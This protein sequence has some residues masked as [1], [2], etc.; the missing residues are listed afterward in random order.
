MES[1]IESA[2]DAPPLSRFQT[3]SLTQLGIMRSSRT[4]TFEGVSGASSVSSNLN[5]KHF[6]R[7][8]GPQRIYQAHVS[9]PDFTV[10]RQKAAGLPLCRLHARASGFR[11]ADH[12]PAEHK[13]LASGSA[14]RAYKILHRIQRHSHRTGAGGSV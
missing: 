8:H 1:A 12:W 5:L 10:L 11:I 9:S 6:V 4:E 2:L 14:I 7:H 3:S 13:S